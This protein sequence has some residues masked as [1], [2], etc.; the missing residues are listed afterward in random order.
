VLAPSPVDHG[1]SH[2]HGHDHG[3]DDHGFSAEHPAAVASPYSSSMAMPSSTGGQA[4]GLA[5][6]SFTIDLQAKEM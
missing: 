2:S 3:A 1:H 6:R 5:H 4:P